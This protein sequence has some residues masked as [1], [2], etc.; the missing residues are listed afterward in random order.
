MKFFLKIFFSELFLSFIY[1]HC[2]NFFCFFV[3]NFYN[4]FISLMPF[5]YHIKQNIIFSVSEINPIVR[6]N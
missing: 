1:F 4:D 3:V 2:F 6:S 5:L